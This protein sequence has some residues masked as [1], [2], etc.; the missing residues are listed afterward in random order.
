MNTETVPTQI[1]LPAGFAQPD[2]SGSSYETFKLK[3]DTSLLFR[4]FPPMKGLMATRAIGLYWKLHFG[5]NGRS[6]SDP[7][8][9]QYR[10]FL[11]LDEKGRDGTVIATDA[12]CD[13]IKA[14]RAKLE[15]IKFKGQEMGKTEEEIKK[16]QAP[17]LA[18]IKSHGNDGKVRIPVMTKE[19]K[20][21]IFLCPYGA[22]KALQKEIKDLT[23]RYKNPDGSQFSPAG[24]RGCFFEFTRTGKASPTSDSVKAHRIVSEDGSERLDIHTLSR[25]DMMRALEV[26]PDLVQLRDE[27]RLTQDQVKDLAA[28]TIDA[29][30]S[31][32]PDEVDRIMG[33]LKNK[34]NKADS[35]KAVAKP[36]PTDDFEFETPEAALSPVP[37]PKV[38]PVAP[39]PPQKP[40]PAATQQAVQSTQAAEKSD[41]EW[42]AMF[43]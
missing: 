36:V 38:D 37:A 1:E 2:Y 42:A 26:L 32:D 15:R 8:R 33:P 24:V 31:Y 21:G 27:S 17:T 3:D 18:W 10:P 6:Q 13:L 35:S 22:W 12:A 43:E 14:Q 34:K 25:D 39:A 28:M 29:N 41:E 16:A 7:T 20:L 30:G 11:C 19:G 4:I 23:G 40:E 5:W 9:T